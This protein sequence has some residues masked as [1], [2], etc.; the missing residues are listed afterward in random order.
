VDN[1]FIESFNG[2]LRDECLNEHW[3]LN[4]R[5]ARDL[6]E[7]WRIEYNEERPGP[8]ALLEIGEPYENNLNLV[9]I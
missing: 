4:I 8:T 6:I 3:S 9:Y 5:Y 1:A 7:K 2:K